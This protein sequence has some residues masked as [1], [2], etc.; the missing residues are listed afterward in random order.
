MHLQYL[1]NPAL[2]PEKT[3]IKNVENGSIFVLMDRGELLGCG[4][5]EKGV[6]YKD[7]VSIG[8]VT[9]REK[10]KKGVGQTILWNLKEWA[11]KNGLKPISGCWYYNMLSRRTLEKAGM[12]AVSRGFDAELI[13]K[14][15]LPLKTGNPPG[16]LV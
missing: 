7:C 4:V 12:V 13:E 10:R 3:L 16:E 8:M 11:Y 6:Y 9:V 2:N 14:E 15:R 5:A 1:K